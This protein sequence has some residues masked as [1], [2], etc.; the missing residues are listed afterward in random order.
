MQQDVLDNDTLDAIYD[1]A[2]DD[3]KWQAALARLTE[4]M[5]A[6]GG[7]YCLFGNRGRVPGVEAAYFSG[8][9]AK[10]GDAYATQH[11][12]S[13]PHV[14][15][16]M[17]TPLRDWFLSHEHFSDRYVS[18]NAFFQEVMRP[19][20]IRWTAGA[21]IW[22]NDDAV[23]CMA[24]HRAFDADP[25]DA[26]DRQRLTLLTPHLGRA[27]SVHLKLSRHRLNAEIGLAAMDGLRFGVAVVDATGHIVFA[28]AAAERF[29]AWRE[30]FRTG[31]AWQLGLRHADC[32][33]R[34]REGIAAAL[35]CASAALPLLDRHGKTVLHATVLPLPPAS[36]WNTLWQKPLAML[37][38][39]EPESSR[40]FGAEALRQLYGF[41]PAEVRL[42]NALMSGQS[43]EEHA[44]E[45][46][47]SAE[48]VRSQVKA[49]LAKSGT[50]R[51]GELIAVLA[52][53]PDLK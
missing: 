27:A 12:L 21:R 31:S 37:V 10:S 14:P 34:L 28:N 13:D 42:A 43:L 32:H 15:L 7:M 41:T 22:E 29:L 35:G 24:F 17:G 50:R 8:Y 5:Q 48:T 18:G 16:G 2:G 4:L 52:R 49:L 46:G 51:Q 1:A 6:V 3:T 53:L 33:A 26:A 38:L 36:R 40:R 19:S 45:C 30:V 47:L 25:F 44:A 23:A 39:S 11:N 9:D 20:G